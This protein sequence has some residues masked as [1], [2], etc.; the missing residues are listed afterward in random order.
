MSSTDASSEASSFASEND[1]L[2]E[3]GEMSGIE[4]LEANIR[5]EANR[6]VGRCHCRDNC[7]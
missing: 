3:Y 5:S 4:G 7:R 2:S 6:D 1:Y